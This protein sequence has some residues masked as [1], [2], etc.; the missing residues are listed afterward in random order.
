M[1]AEAFDH[2]AAASWLRLGI[3]RIDLITD[4]YDWP[5]RAR[6]C[7]Y[8]SCDGCAVKFGKQR[9][10][11]LKGILRIR[12]GTDASLFHETQHTAM[13]AACDARNFGIAWRPSESVLVW[14]S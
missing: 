7:R 4:S 12:L 13:N 14:P 5:S 1:N 8:A 2:R 3:I 6:A 11:E 9:L 10:I